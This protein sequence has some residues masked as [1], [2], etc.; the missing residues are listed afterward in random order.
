[1]SNACDV[2]AN[3]EHLDFFIDDQGTIFQRI[4]DNKYD[5]ELYDENGK[6]CCTIQQMFDWNVVAVKELITKE[7]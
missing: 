1:M 6:D 2:T 4:S 7:I 5:Y 3:W